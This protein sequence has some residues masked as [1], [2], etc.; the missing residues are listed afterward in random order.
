MRKISVC[1]I[2]SIFL[3]LITSCTGSGFKKYFYTKKHTNIIIDMLLNI[4]I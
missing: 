1:F 3:M 2:L 4:K